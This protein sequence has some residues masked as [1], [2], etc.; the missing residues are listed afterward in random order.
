MY[1]CIHGEREGV[2]HLTLLFMDRHGGTLVEDRG[3]IPQTKTARQGRG[4]YFFCIVI[5]LE[6]R[7]ADAP[8]A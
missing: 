3:L 6:S 4:P 2:T 1:V 8:G 7:I 5:H